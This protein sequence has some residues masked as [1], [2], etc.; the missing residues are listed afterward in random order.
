[1]MDG[2]ATALGL[3][4][5]NTED[6]DDDALSAPG[7]DPTRQRTQGERAGDDNDDESWALVMAGARGATR[8]I[9]Q[10]QEREP[11]P[12]NQDQ[13]PPTV[14]IAAQPVLSSEL[15][16]QKDIHGNTA[17]QTAFRDFATNYTQM[18]VYLAMVG[19]QK[20]VTMIHTLGT[21]YSIRAA[22]NAYQ[23]KVLGFVGDRRATKGANTRLLA[24]I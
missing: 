9:S 15:A 16:L 8:A 4:R 6:T 21:Y 11:Q 10:T 12:A 2:L 14:Q 23:G 22:T 3:G 5:R 7:A 1:M 24:A 17:K 18:R 19:E 20:N 13:P